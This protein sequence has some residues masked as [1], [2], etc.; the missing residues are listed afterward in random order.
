MTPQAPQGSASV[1]NK[2]LHTPDSNEAS[3]T[4]QLRQERNRTASP[5][6]IDR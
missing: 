4:A 2:R 3:A 1:V 5:V 6:R